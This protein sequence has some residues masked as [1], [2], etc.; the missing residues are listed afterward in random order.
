M[1]SLFVFL[2]D[3]NWSV[4]SAD[5]SLLRFR[6][7]MCN[8]EGAIQ[9]PSGYSS[10]VP[11]TL[12]GLKPE[13]VQLPL[14]PIYEGPL[15]YTELNQKVNASQKITNKKWTSKTS[16]NWSLS[17]EFYVEPKYGLSRTSLEFVKSTANKK[18]ALASTTT[19][20]TSKTSSKIQTGQ[21]SSDSQ[22]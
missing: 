2:S 9:Y 5:I 13:V 12:L 6:I 7:L 21:I 19:M 3:L 22:D 20:K 18:T 10:I 11:D 17:E 15:K 16:V 8:L 4:S 14:E 1:S